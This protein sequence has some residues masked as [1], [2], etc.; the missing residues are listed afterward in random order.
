M[1]TSK[2]AQKLKSDLLKYCNNVVAGKTVSCKKHKQACQRF[3]DD[4]EL[5]QNGGP[6]VF[7]A[8]KALKFI[9]WAYLFRHTKGKLAG[10]RIELLLPIKFVVSNIYGWYHRDTGYRRFNRM[11]LQ[12]ARKN[13]KSQ[14]MSLMATYEAFV[15]SKDLAEVYTAATKRKQARVVYDE[16]AR[17]LRKCPELKGKYNIR[18]STYTIEHIGPNSRGSFITT[19]S[20]EDEQKGD[21]YNPQCAIIDEYHLHGTN[22]YVSAMDTGMGAR[23]EPLLSIITTAGKDL[24]APCYTMEYKLAAK[25]LDP[26]NPMTMDNMFVDIFEMEIND[27]GETIEIN[28][29]KIAPG[30]L[31]DKI[32]DPE[33]WKKANPVICS[34]PEGVKYLKDQLKKAESVPELMRDF[35][36]KHCNVWVNQR[37]AGYMPL[38]RW[39]ACGRDI[40][41][42]PEFDRKVCYIGLDLSAKI[43][44]T[45]AGI[46]IPSDGKYIIFGQSFIPETKFHEKISTDKVPY[47]LWEQQGFLTVTRGDVV[48]YTQV[49]DWC[50]QFV[51]EHALFIQE[52]CLD[53]WGS[54]QISADLI[55]DG[56]EVV[57][58]VQGIKTLSEPTKVYR[59]EVFKGNIIHNNNP[60]VT[61]AIGNAVVDSVDRNENII[62]SKKK[63]IERIDPIAAIINGFTRAIISDTIEAGYNQDDVRSLA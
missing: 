21:A 24:S 52:W 29:E 37:D 56:Y 5:S 17:M 58:I 4:I 9:A 15:F 3:L 57:D 59:E 36:T 23:Q 40:A 49:V 39:A 44:L 28:G 55:D 14:L 7:D 10:K 51:S 43:D 35:M 30:S 20:K 62:L 1:A 13:M 16:C 53:P 11:Y 54:L 63:S 27:T 2:K 50:K 61:M 38:E 60:V 42:F 47:D 34:Y 32:D 41:D 48:N 6:F 22:G 12:V 19:L 18:E 26:D 46:I 25:I 45:S 31:I 33:A 8:E